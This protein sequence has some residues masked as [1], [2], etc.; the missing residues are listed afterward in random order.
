MYFKTLFIL[1]QHPQDAKCFLNTEKDSP[2]SEEFMVKFTF[3]TVH[4]H[5][6]TVVA[7]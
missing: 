6:C 3:K 1:Q 4:Q 2:R 5:S 7:L